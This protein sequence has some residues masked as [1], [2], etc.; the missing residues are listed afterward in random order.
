MEA[1][2]AGINES[3]KTDKNHILMPDGSIYKIQRDRF[4]KDRLK[5]GGETIM[6]SISCAS[7]EEPLLVYQKDGLGPLKRCYVDRIA[8]QTGGEKDLTHDPLKCPTCK[9]TVGTPMIY[10]KE[11]RPAVRMDNSKFHKSRYVVRDSATTS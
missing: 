7:C 3:K 11:D 8:W 6:L 2:M 4:Q 9:E 10:K 5:L 1:I